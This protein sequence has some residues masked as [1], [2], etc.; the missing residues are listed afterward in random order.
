M[1]TKSG[2]L[3]CPMPTESATT[4]RGQM[5]MFHVNSSTSMAHLAGHVAAR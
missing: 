2:D 1:Y 3:A 4:M 5:D